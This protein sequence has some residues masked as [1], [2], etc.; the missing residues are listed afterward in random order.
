MTS[1]GLFTGERALV[2]GSASNIGRGIALALAR[3]GAGVILADVDMERN[4]AVAR[5]IGSAGGAAETIT[6]DL[7]QPGGWREVMEAVEGRPPQMFVHAACPRRLEADTPAKVSEETWDEML[8]TNVRSGFFVGRELGLRMQKAGVRG[9]LL[10][11]TSLH[12]DAPRNLAHYSAAKA[13]MTMAMK[14]LARAFGPSSIR[15][16][17]LAPGAVPGGGASNMDDS[18]QPKR[19][20]PLQRF[21]TPEDMAGMAIAL[22]S[23][24]FS[25]YVT[26]VTLPVD[27]GLA[28]FN[29]IDMPGQEQA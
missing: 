15:V 9:R 25:G 28:L 18:F 8:N 1:L 6:V 12:A 13:G 2:T 17:A 4:A 14:E 10:F 23:D 19:K 27:G 7:S 20:I 5:E 21:G 11:I 24:R 3:E 29:W 22:L 16:N 26:G